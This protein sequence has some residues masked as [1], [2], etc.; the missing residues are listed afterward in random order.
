VRLLREKAARSYRLGIDAG[1]KLL[2][3]GFH[4]V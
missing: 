2:D 3:A 1:S 4:D